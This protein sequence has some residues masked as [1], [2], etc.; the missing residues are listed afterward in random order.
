MKNMGLFS[1]SAV[2]AVAVCMLTI[3]PSLYADGG[4]N[5]QVVSPNYGVSGGNINDSSRR[6]CC[7]GTLGAFPASAR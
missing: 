1:R 7:S 5:H 2:L 4:A 3:A 6:F